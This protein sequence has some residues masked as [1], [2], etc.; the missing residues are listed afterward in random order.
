MKRL[1]SN[2]KIQ[3]NNNMYQK[4]PETSDLG[5]KIVEHGIILIHEIGFESFTFKKLGQK[6]NSNESSIYRYFE[7]KHNLLLYLTSWYWSWLEYQ[8]VF[9]ISNIENPKDR[10]LKA[11]E[12]LT[13]PVEFDASFEHIDE[14]LLHT[15]VINE[16]SKSYLTKEVDT[17]NKEGYYSVYK[18][19]TLRIKDMIAEMNPLY[20]FPS[21]LA[22]MI[23]E[24]ALHQG[25]LK[26]HFESI[27]DCSNSKEIQ[28]FLV[29]L[30]I[31]TLKNNSHVG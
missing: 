6:I 19:L 1:L 21:S 30:T 11:I 20:M 7:N 25:F 5:K 2:I 16:F 3:I 13:S 23:V 10:L 29:N 8:L 9:G 28:D 12:V 4:D 17:K 26:D 14:V 15:I 24:G 18:R 31:N 27:T 22:S